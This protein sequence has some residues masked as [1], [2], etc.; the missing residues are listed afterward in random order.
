MN[1]KKFNYRHLALN[2]VSHKKKSRMKPLIKIFLNKL[3]MRKLRKKM[4]MM[5]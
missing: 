4:M 3:G 5:K 1:L 2:Q